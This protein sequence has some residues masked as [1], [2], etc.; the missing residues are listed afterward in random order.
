MFNQAPGFISVSSGPSH[1]F[2]LVNEAYYPLVGHREII[3]KPVWDALPEVAGQGFE[4]L[5]D[6]VFATGRPVVVRAQKLSV[7]R[8]PGGGWQSYTLTWCTSRSSA[9][10]EES[11][12][13]RRQCRRGHNA[14]DVHGGEGYAV[15][16][17]HA[18]HHALER[19]KHEVFHAFL[20][21]IGLPGMQNREK[22]RE[23]GF[24]KFI[25]KPADPGETFPFLRVS[26]GHIL[27][28]ECS[29][30]ILSG[31]SAQQSVRPVPSYSH[32]VGSH[33]SV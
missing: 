22:A 18:P 14:S 3:G 10:M 13:C 9:K 21:D 25:V 16:I 23:A 30:N 8:E 6:G 2:E 11:P 5:L 15:A 32:S 31:L 20:L 7:Q 4:A 33:A 27:P 17:H 28:T 12:D 24:D 1:V 29:V 19:A 26:V